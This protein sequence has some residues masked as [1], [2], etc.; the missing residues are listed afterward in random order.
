MF[1]SPVAGRYFN[2]G[3]ERFVTFKVLD[4]CSIVAINDVLVF[5]LVTEILQNFHNAVHTI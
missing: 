5:L 1:I 4:Q 2:R 3:E